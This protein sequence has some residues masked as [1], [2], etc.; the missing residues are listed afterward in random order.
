MIVLFVNVI[1]LLFLSGCWDRVEIENRAFTVGI[2]IDLMDESEKNPKLKMTQQVIVPSVFSTSQSKQGQ[3]YRNLAGTGETVFDMNRMSTNHASTKLTVTHLRVVLFSEAVA[4]QEKL[5][6]NLM[7]IFLREME[8][9]RTIKVVIVSDEAQ[10]LLDVVPEHEI[11]PAFYIH[12]L[13]T[14]DDSLIAIKSLR[15][16]EVHEEL[17]AKTS[18]MIPQIKKF[19]DTNAEYEGFAIYNAASQK[20]VGTLRGDEAKGVVLLTGNVRT[21]SLNTNVDGNKIANEI[22][23]V[24]NEIV[25]KNKDKSNLKFDINLKVTAG[26]AEVLGSVNI[27]SQDNYDLIKNALEEEIKKLTN[28]SIDK[29]QNELKTD[30]LGLDEF[31]HQY[32]FE[33]WKSIKDNWEDGEA[34]FSKSDINVNVNVIIDQSGNINRVQ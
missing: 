10:G 5:F 26:I 15:L 30:I 9:R 13:L 14:N 24:K 21:G 33:F 12:G 7:D 25:L 18:F 29:L 32:H 2:A 34:Y 19:N 17:L 20:V 23:K 28:Q 1:A 27:L 6:A 11:V 22:M 3:A 4:K 8:M 31:M 16:G